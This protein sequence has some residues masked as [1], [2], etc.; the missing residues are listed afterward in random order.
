MKKKQGIFPMPFCVATRCI[1]TATKTEIPYT[2]LSGRVPRGNPSFETVKPD[3]VLAKST[4][5]PPQPL[6]PPTYYSSRIDQGA[7]ITPMAF[8][9]CAR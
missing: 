2:E 5:S 3:L 4:Y 9:P 7:T 6:G 8:W 1:A